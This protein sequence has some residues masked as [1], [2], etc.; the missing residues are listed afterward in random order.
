MPGEG[1]LLYG[2]VRESFTQQVAS[3][4]ERTSQLGEPVWAGDQREVWEYGRGLN[5][6]CLTPGHQRGR[7]E[8]REWARGADGAGWLEA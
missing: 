1:S 2:E 3:E 8:E 7:R 6:A 4:L 5:G